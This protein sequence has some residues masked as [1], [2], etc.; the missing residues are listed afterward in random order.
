MKILINYKKNNKIF[1]EEVKE[2]NLYTDGSK[3]DDII[4]RSFWL[5]EDGFC[6]FFRISSKVDINNAEIIST[7]V[8]MILDINA[9]VNIYIDN[10][11][12]FTYAKKI[13][14]NK[15]K[16]KDWKNVGNI[17]A[18]KLLYIKVKAHFG[19]E[20][21]EKADKLAK[22]SLNSEFYFVK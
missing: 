4:G 6:K 2:Y 5:K 11:N 1:N 7:Y 9:L 19:I 8:C 3:K 21:N 20:G 12:A 22:K 15:F 17:Q 18:L 16:N 13:N 10:E 14:E